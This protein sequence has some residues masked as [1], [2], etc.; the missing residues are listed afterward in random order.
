MR[1]W[2]TP[3]SYSATSVF[4]QD[5]DKAFC[6]KQEGE[7]CVSVEVKH[8]TNDESKSNRDRGVRTNL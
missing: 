1:L 7:F 2:K 8:H 6:I 4:R 3:Y 5:T